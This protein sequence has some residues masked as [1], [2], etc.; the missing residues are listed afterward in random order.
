MVRVHP[1][2]LAASS[3]RRAPEGRRLEAP[4]PRDQRLGALPHRQ[5]H[6]I[7]KLFLNLSKEEQRQ[8]FLAR[9]DEP[10]KNWKFSAA[11]VHERRFWDDYQ[12]AYSEVLSKTSTEWAPWYVIPA[13]D[14][15]LARVAAAGVIANA[16]I[17]IDPQYP[18]VSEEAREALQVAKVGAGGRGRTGARRTEAIR[19][20]TR[21]TGKRGKR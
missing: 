1:E 11:D 17:D 5:R 7:V 10:D 19:T 21:K 20:S 4:L 3:C 18:T 16:L 8:R 9:I 12:Q 15:P 2:I 13:D 6:R 14:K